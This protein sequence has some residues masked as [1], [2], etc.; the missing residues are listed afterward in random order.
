EAPN[1]KPQWAGCMALGIWCLEFLWSL[2]PGTWIFLLLMVATGGNATQADSAL[3]P[4]HSVPPMVGMEGRLEILLPGTLL[5]AKSVH[6]RSVII[7]R[8]AETRPHG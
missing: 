2:V 5:E 1:S 6:P 4:P 8:I 3:R 7:L